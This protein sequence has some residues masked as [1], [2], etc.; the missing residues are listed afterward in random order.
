MS[1]LAQLFAN[2]AQRQAE[3]RADK[4]AKA[5]SAAEEALR[6][7]AYPL[8]AFFGDYLEI[9]SPREFLEVLKEEQLLP[10]NI[11]QYL[12]HNREFCRLLK[13]GIDDGFDWDEDED[14]DDDYESSEEDDYGYDEPPYDEDGGYEY[15]EDEEYDYDLDE[16]ETNTPSYPLNI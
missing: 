5:E 7:F 4:I 11:L 14:Y 2:R 9:D 3:R 8:G 1:K 10:D 12:A 15:D 13:Q 6:A 16:D